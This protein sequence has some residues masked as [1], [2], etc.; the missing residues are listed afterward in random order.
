MADSITLQ[1]L[2]DI[3]LAQAKE[4]GFGATPE[5]IDVAEKIALIHTEVS[6][7]YEAYR[8]NVFEG[9]HRFDI[10]LGDIIQRVLH[11]AGALNLDIEAAILEKIRL[12]NSRE[13]I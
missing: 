11:L 3:I 13:W 10:E 1:E 4:K 7:A 12:N 5:E 9:K 2:T 8:H 6:E